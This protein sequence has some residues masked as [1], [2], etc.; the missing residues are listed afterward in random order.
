[1][2]RREESSA[3]TLIELL[4]VMGIMLV[5]AGISVA[6]YFS[7]VEGSGMNA[8]ASH[9]RSTILLARQSAM[10]QGRE[11]QVRFQGTVTNC[12]SYVIV[13]HGG[14]GK[15]DAV[16][17]KVLLDS[18][19][20]LTPSYEGAEIYNLDTPDLKSAKVEEVDVES[21]STNGYV[22]IK[23]DK[24]IWGNGGN[25][26]GWQIHP[27]TSMPEKWGWSSPPGKLV[28]SSTGN[29]DEWTTT[30]EHRGEPAFDVTVK[31]TGKV[32]IEYREST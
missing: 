12:C 11:V 21:R 13:A 15:R 1:M 32:E 16:N 20:R 22:K 26:Y 3:F 29:V 19:S 4:T 31:N 7:L 30:I 17:P 6:S 5:M 25:D 14:Q 18:F 10:L 2:R 24:A 23:T 27:A 8:A 28:F 9:L